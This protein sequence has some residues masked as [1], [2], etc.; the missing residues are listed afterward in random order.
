MT[1]LAAKTICAEEKTC[2]YVFISPVDGYATHVPNDAGNLSEEDPC[3]RQEL[4]GYLA[5]R[6]HPP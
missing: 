4:Q 2:V 5:Y 6:K 3:V 1:Q